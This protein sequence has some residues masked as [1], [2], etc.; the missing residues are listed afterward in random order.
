LRTTLPALSVVG[1]EAQVA[2]KR[3]KPIRTVERMSKKPAKVIVV[4]VGVIEPPREDVV[5]EMEVIEP[6]REDVV[7]EVEAMKKPPAA[8][9]DSR[10]LCPQAHSP[11]Y[12]AA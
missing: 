3:A 2:K 5:V 1:V 8:W 11:S 10:P 7:V 4:E 12:G 9:I 6:R